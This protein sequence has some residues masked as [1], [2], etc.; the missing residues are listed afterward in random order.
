MRTL[1]LVLVVM[2]LQGCTTLSN[3][4]KMNRVLPQVERMVTLKDTAIDRVKMEVCGKDESEQMLLQS[5]AHQIGWKVCPDALAQENCFVI[6]Y[7]P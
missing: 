4:N 5:I 1:A 2:V 7:N 6:F 3:I